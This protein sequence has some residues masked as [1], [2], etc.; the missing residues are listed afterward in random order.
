MG[1][2]GSSETKEGEKKAGIEEAHVDLEI[3]QL[4]TEEERQKRKQAIEKN[5]SLYEW[6]H[7][8]DG[9]TPSHIKQIP[10]CE[11]DEVTRKWHKTQVYDIVKA[12]AD[13]G[14]K[15]IIDESTDIFR[16][17]GAFKDY[18]DIY[19][20]EPGKEPRE[21]TVS[22]RWRDD[23]EFARQKL[24]GVLPIY[25]KRFKEVPAKFPVTNDMLQGVITDGETLESMIEKGKMYWV[26]YDFLLG[27]RAPPER[28]MCVPMIL[29]Y[30]DHRDKLMPAAI[31]L[32]QGT[33]EADFVRFPIFTPSG[34][35]LV[36]NRWLV[37]KILCNS[38]EGSLHEVSNHLLM[39][40]LSMEVVYVSLKR[41]LAPTHPI[42]ELLAAHFWYTL[43]INDGARN[44]LM[45]DEESAVPKVMCMGYQGMVDL[46]VKGWK[47]YSMETY[48]IE[49][50]FKERDIEELPGYYYRDDA[51]KVWGCIFK[52]VG[53]V[54]N[55]FYKDDETIA[56]DEELQAFVKEFTDPSIGNLRGSPFLDG[57][58]STR[59]QLIRF[60]TEVIWS[61]SAYHAAL[62]NGQYD[63]FGYIPNAPGIYHRAAPTKQDTYTDAQVAGG[64]PSKSMTGFQVAF[65]HVLSLPTDQKLAYFTHDQNYMKGEPNVLK[66]HKEWQE[67]LSSISKQIQERNKG[68]DA[69]YTYLDPEQIACGIAI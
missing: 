10:E 23:E 18:S 58:A 4:C 13:L 24:A 19:T 45:K 56:T 12:A 21:P 16:D 2:C 68:L 53:S 9:I 22:D 46:L 8:P 29:F 67:E 49:K 44:T 66:L 52:Y 30:I 55:E 7:A 64:F 3:P 51:R 41:T 14:I 48:D 32:G 61:C 40:H 26:D 27:I 47:E 60:C 15:T 35:D 50:G 39:T 28:N 5:R 42:H 57:K 11:G 36:T 59:E 43:F 17:E 37:A 1:C 38:A 20:K 62:N 34:E 31:R 69:P 25:I 63:Y 6:E 33:E 65:I 54:V